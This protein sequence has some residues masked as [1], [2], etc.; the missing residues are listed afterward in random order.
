[1]EWNDLISSPDFKCY[2]RNTCKIWIMYTCRSEF[3]HHILKW[4]C[5]VA[6]LNNF[7]CLSSFHRGKGSCS[8]P[9][10]R[11]LFIPPPTSGRRENGTERKSKDTVKQRHRRTD[12]TALN[13]SEIHRL[14][15]CNTFGGFCLHKFCKYFQSRRCSSTVV[16][17]EMYCPVIWVV[18]VVLLYV[19]ICFYM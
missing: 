14:H 7:T 18:T 2:V 11:R 15:A 12:L 5:G 1:M 19:R 17:S 9:R 16:E 10:W 6:H 13:W 4:T 8:T 3:T